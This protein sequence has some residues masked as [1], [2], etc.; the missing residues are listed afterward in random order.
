M[1]LLGTLKFNLHVIGDVIGD[2]YN[3]IK[4]SVA[5]LVI[6]D[7]YNLIKKSVALLVI[8]DGYNLIK[9]YE[10]LLKRNTY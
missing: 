1:G 2:G 8:G 5:L 10:G 9:K 7:G 3:L 6:G 4:K